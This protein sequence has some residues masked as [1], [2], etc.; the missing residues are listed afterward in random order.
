MTK[1]RSVD[2]LGV[3]LYHFKGQGQ[4]V[5]CVVIA[6]WN[7]LMIVDRIFVKGKWNYEWQQCN[8]HNHVIYFIIC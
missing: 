7:C 6:E 8:G 1:N 4:S 5:T 3:L 2:V